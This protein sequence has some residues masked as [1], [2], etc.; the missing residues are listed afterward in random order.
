M[1]SYNLQCVT[2]I[3]SDFRSA[4][5]LVDNQ[6]ESLFI[7]VSNNSF[8]ISECKS[9][10]MWSSQNIVYECKPTFV[11]SNTLFFRSMSQNVGKAF[12]EFNIKTTLPSRQQQ[13][14]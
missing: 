2:L 14:H 5:V 1:V 10:K 8:H 9:F 6:R 11:K 7:I 13:I 3:C 12:R 4:R